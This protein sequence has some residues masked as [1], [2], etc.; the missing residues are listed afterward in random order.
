MHRI[1]P[2]EATVIER[3][4]LAGSLL[5]GRYRLDEKIA[6]GGFGSIYRAT[7]LA[8]NRAV[9]VKIL[10][11]RFRT[12]PGISARF[13]R[14]AA[15]MATLHDPHTVAAYDHG[16]APDGT[17]Y[18]VMELL[19]GQSLYDRFMSRGGLPWQH[20]VAIARGVCSSLA[21]AHDNGIVH[22]DLKPANIY[23]EQRGFVKVLDFGI[24]KVMSGSEMGGGDLTYVGQMIGTFEYMP[25]E[26]LVGGT[27]TP[28]SDVFALGVVMYEMITGERPFGEVDGPAGMLAA[29]FGT[30]PPPLASRAQVPPALDR[31]V[32]RCLER[33]P[34]LRYA[35]ATE[36]AADLEQL[37]IGEVPP[38]RV[39][40]PT[41][42]GI[43][44]PPTPRRLAAGT[45]TPVPADEPDVAPH[46]MPIGVLLIAIAVAAGVAAAIGF[47]M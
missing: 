30:V 22:R 45:Y 34:T 36:L 9:A 12:D 20:M 31:I 41:L 15:A 28:R 32:M 29:L 6:D 43:A 18:I 44:P 47:L 42:H 5:D 23:L 3:D 21:E 26:Q 13:R 11:R 4:P 27:C 2:D 16:E 19:V 24:A 33:E 46:R 39:S 10:H 1:D 14:E 8:S 40:I 35:N 37:S 38:P 17:L 7:H 25:P